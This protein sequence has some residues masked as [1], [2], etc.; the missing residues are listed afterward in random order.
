MVVEVD[1]TEQLVVSTAELVQ[2]CFDGDSC[3][4][5]NH[6]AGMMLMDEV[7]ETQSRDA[8]SLHIH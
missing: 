1:D 8:S 7:V 6:R 2:L 3:I 5:N 4:E